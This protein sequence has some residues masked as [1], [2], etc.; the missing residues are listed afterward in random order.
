MAKRNELSL[1]QKVRVPEALETRHQIQ[2]ANEFGVS[3]SDVSRMKSRETDIIQRWQEMLSQKLIHQTQYSDMFFAAFVRFYEE[4][5]IA[6][7]PVT[8]KMLKEGAAFIVDEN[9]ASGSESGLLMS[10]GE[11]FEASDSWLFRLKHRHNVD[12]QRSNSSAE[13]IVACKKSSALSI[14]SQFKQLVD[15]GYLVTGGELTWNII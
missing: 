4:Q 1:D 14:I 11:S 9:K 12:L 5:R 6:G 2:V 13:N 3:Q 10:Q 8:T 7:I 15:E